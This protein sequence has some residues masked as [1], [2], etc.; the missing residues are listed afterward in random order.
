MT[1]AMN[2]GVALVLAGSLAGNMAAQA[3][4]KKKKAHKAVAAKP[5][6]PAGTQADVQSLKDSMAAQHPS[7]FTPPALVMMRM[8][9][10][11]HAGSTSRR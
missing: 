8:P 4:P 5:V 9:R 11:T 7:G 1:T 6:E 2:L 3:A 10:S